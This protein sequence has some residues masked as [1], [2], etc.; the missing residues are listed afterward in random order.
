[1]LAD[2]EN[3]PWP[4]P[5]MGVPFVLDQP[6][7]G[8]VVDEATG[9]RRVRVVSR[10]DPKNARLTPR[11]GMKVWFG[12][13]GWGGWGWE[14]VSWEGWAT[15]IAATALIVVPS[16]RAEVRGSGEMWTLLWCAIVVAA[17]LAICR[18]KGTSPGGPRLK[19]EYERTRD[20][21][22]RRRIDP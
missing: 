6:K 7:R 5:S 1:M 10:T 17:L 16:W 13:R 19:E 21:S 15:M 18:A 11:R 8:T 9:Q 22:S 20:A 2:K 14:P 12:P 3:W 4:R